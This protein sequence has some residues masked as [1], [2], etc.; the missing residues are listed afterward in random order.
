[1]TGAEFKLA[2]SFGR[3]VH[4]VAIIGS[5][6]SV[7]DLEAAGKKLVADAEYRSATTA[8]Q[9]LTVRGST[10]DHIWTEV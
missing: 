2:T 9:A 6:A 7:A 3:Q 1:M 8:S 5:F 10:Q 4:E